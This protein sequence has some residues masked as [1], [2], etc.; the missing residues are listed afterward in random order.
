LADG[1]TPTIEQIDEAEEDWAARECFW[2]AHYRNA[3]A[4]LANHTDGGEGVCGF[5]HT[6]EFRAAQSMRTKASMTPE[7]R[8]AH[9]AA[10]KRVASDPD[11]VKRQVEK[12]KER[13]LDPSWRASQG[14]KTKASMTPERLARMSEIGKA[15]M[16]GDRL[17]THIE[18][19]KVTTSDPAWRARQSLAIQAIMTPERRA[20][21][22]AKTIETMTPERRQKIAETQRAVAADPEYKARQRM[23]QKQYAEK[24]AADPAASAARSQ[25]LKAGWTPERRAAAAERALATSTARWK[26]FREGKNDHRAIKDFSASVELSDGIA[27]GIFPGGNGSGSS[28]S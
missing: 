25:K 27:P 2:I 21:I 11:W 28:E 8:K 19:L 16:V 1:V 13:S 14:A 3:D 6:E 17:A 26:K 7:R 18:K 20:T 5:V 22:S 10:M 4:R 23:A 24:L 12:L 15:L 9:S